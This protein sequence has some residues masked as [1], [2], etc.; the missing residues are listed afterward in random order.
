VLPVLVLAL[1][2][3]AGEVPAP[4]ADKTPSRVR[5]GLLIGAVG[6]A[7]TS[8]Y[9]IGAVLT[10]DKPSG[11]PLAIAGG[12]ASLGLVSASVTM[13]ALSGRKNP[14]GLLTYVLTTVGIGLAGAAIG[15][16]AAHFG[17]VN[18]G[19]GRTATHGVIIGLC[20]TET[21]LIELSRLVR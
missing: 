21:V 17:S 20:V 3:H 1:T 9:T 19:P 4:V 16:I 13:L 18:P 15:G 8:A 12:V 6:L 10:G 11:H 2:L 5:D 7:V 14:W